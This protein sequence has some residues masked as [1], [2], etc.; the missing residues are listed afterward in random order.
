MVNNID[1][2]HWLNPFF[3]AHVQKLHVFNKKFNEKE[4]N[5]LYQWN[6]KTWMIKILFQKW[7]KKFD[8]EMKKPNC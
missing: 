7:L 6:K 5:F 3:I 8:N 2:S 1:K 4:F